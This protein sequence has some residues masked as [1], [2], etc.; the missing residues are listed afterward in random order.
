[1]VVAA[2]P[3]PKMP[4]QM[5]DAS[6]PAEIIIAGIAHASIDMANPCITLVPSPVSD[7]LATVLT[8]RYSVDV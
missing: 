5:N 8:G 1:M 2:I 4:P 7:D 6:M 3:T